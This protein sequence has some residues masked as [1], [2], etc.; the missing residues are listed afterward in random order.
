MKMT[1]TKQVATLMGGS[2]LLTSVA[3][4]NLG[5]DAICIERDAEHVKM[6]NRRL[7]TEVQHALVG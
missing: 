5:R 3:A 4:A 6:A 2:S 7:A 1:I